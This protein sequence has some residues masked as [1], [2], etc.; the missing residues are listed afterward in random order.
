MYAVNLLGTS[1]MSRELGRFPSPDYSMR[2]VFDKAEEDLDN[3]LLIDTHM[4]PEIT[5]IKRFITKENL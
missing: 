1:S 4:A 2:K 5:F 3:I